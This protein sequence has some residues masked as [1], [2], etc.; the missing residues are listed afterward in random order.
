[1]IEILFLKM[2]FKLNMFTF[3]VLIFHFGF[4]LFS[5]LFYFLFFYQIEDMLAKPSCKKH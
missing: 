2:F 3:M 1:M 4:V 5:L